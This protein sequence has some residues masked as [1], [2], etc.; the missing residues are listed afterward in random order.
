[1]VSQV[2]LEEGRSSTGE[3]VGLLWTCNNSVD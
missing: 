1:V 3:N 2:S